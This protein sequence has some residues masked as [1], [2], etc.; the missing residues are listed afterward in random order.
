MRDKF[1][2]WLGRVT[3]Y[4]YKTV[5]LIGAVITILFAAL[6]A[7]VRMESSWISMLPQGHESVKAFRKAIEEFGG[8][9]N[10]VVALEGSDK[11]T[12][13]S[14]A[15]ELTPQLEEVMVEYEDDDGNFIRTNAVKRVEHTYDV[16]YFKNH[17]FMLEKAKNLDKNKNLYAD[18]NLVPFLTHLNDV[19]EAQW[20][21]DAD[22]LAKQ[23][24]DAE[25]GL[26]GI[27]Q[28]FGVISNFAEGTI[29][30]SA[31]VQYGV[32]AA[33]VGDGYY[34]SSD[35]KMLLIFVSPTISVDMMY[36]AIAMVDTIETRL[37][38]FR[39]K[40]PEVRFGQTGMQVLSRDE[41][42]FG[43]SDMLR[44]LAFALVLILTIFILSFRMWTGPILAMM[45]LLCGIIW[46]VGIAQLVY[47]RLNI[48]TAMCS[49]ILVGL[50][51]DFAIHIISSYS[52]LRHAGKSVE[53][54]VALS[55]RK[56]GT[57]LVTGALTTA[58][59]FLAITIMGTSAFAEFGFVVGTGII[60]C[61]V[62]SL[63]LLPAVIVAKEKIWIKLSKKSQP[64]PVD[65]EFKIIG[66]ISS[67]SKTSARV[68][69]IIS[70]IITAFLIY[71]I[72]DGK[73][74]QNYMDL[75]PEGL[76][77]VRLQK[78]IVKRFHM[79]PDNMIAVFDDL[80]EVNRVEDK[81]NSQPS[82]G[83]VESIATVL[84]SDEKQ[85]KRRPYIEEIKAM[86]QNIPEEIPIASGELV[87]QL[88]RLSDNI[89][90]MSSM[91]F[92]GG[93]D[94][95]FD[96][97]NEFVGL[98]EDGD[99][100]GVNR[101]VAL[102]EYIDKN[103]DAINNLER[104]QHHFTSIMRQRV[105]QMA[106][107]EKITMDLVPESFRDRYVSNDGSHYLMAFYSRNDIWDGLYTSPYLNTLLR[108]VPEAT[109]TPIFM[110]A[111]IDISKREGAFAFAIALMVIL[112]LLIADFKSVKTA[113]ITIIPL[114]TASVWLFGMMG[115]FDIKYTV[116]NVIGFPLIL[117]I[118]IDD[119]VHVIHRYRIE[120]KR[121]LAYAMSSIG[122]AILLTSLTTML[123]FGSL[124]W[125][126]YRGYI[127]LGLIVL[128]GIGL[129]FFASV[130]ILPA[131][132]K[133]VWGGKKKHPEFFR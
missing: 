84:P 76:E 99:Q 85:N 81:L 62:I 26:D 61:L 71:K 38:V 111:L 119:G 7:N 33:T 30:D 53:Q 118:G 16:E 129:C 87:E 50:G 39:E 19:Y 70:L 6:A 17:G 95:V 126:E 90:E 12:L 73:M 86:Q 23:E 130:V 102:A 66:R 69:I 122:K 114:A 2:D 127:G 100:V 120:G 97:A 5:I 78:E 89:T 93:L 27:Y 25:R 131:V 125:S 51:V 9:T 36:P 116:V 15:D 82:I 74:M 43:M 21:S 92:I 117:G 75:E 132:M 47:G 45:V 1:F 55:F 115:L 72:P 59:A 18:Y 28:L 91:A 48:M 54:A 128:I 121:K 106:N 65:M 110:K 34:L 14:A 77:S 133:I 63:F 79:S 58:I 44:N 60:C 88:Y 108:S 20:V 101:A 10:I 46:D 32:D 56:I 31:S 98:D 8:A 24:K 104:F 4:N 68:A 11:E 22:N 96:K 49:V 29:N 40:Y 83:M 123:G 67:Y 3:Y 107:P 52:E 80:D 41:M 64:K 35:K 42:K 113:L 109:G 103:A 13:I 105:T 94:R 57:G 124:M 112:L 37:D